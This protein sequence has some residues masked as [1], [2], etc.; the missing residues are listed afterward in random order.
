MNLT[1]YKKAK[2]AGATLSY[3]GSLFNIFLDG[4]SLGG[5]RLEE[6][7]AQLRAIEEQLSK[8]GDNLK[9]KYEEAKASLETAIADAEKSKA[10][11]E[12]AMAAKKPKTLKTGEGKKAPAK[13]AEAKK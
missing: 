7:K 11:F 5:F 2:D 9:S 1:G 4:S 10:D 8:V 6:A 3:K 13:K 12:K